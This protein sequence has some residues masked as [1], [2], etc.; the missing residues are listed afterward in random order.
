VLAAG[1]ATASVALGF[2]AVFVATR[3]TRRT[4]IAA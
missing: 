2:L 4:R 3:L 1:Y